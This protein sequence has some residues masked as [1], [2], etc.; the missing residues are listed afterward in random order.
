M[1]QAILPVE[2]IQE[3]DVDL[4]LLEELA[5]DNSFCEWFA[6]ELDLPD[7]TSVNSAWRSVS[8]F[9]L[10]ET[11]ILF[12]Y[13]SNAQKI[14]VLIENKLDASFQNEQFNRYLKRADE[15]M[16]KKECDK[17]FT[18]LIAPEQ[19]CESQS[20][21]ESYLTYELI[22]K[23]LD[24]LGSKRNLFKSKLLQIAIEKLRRGYQPINSIPV[25][26]FWLSYWKNIEE[27]HPT[28]TM[29]KPNIVPH[30]SNWPLLHDDR[31]K[32]IVFCHKLRQGNTDAT[33]KGFPKEV[34]LKIKEILPD[35]AKFEKH[36]RNFSIRVFSGKVDRTKDFYEQIDKVEYGL[37][38]LDKLR[39]WIIEN[40]NWLQQT[41]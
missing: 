1:E 13:N 28:F 12:S 31:L 11:D 24:F 41:V 19:Y 29:E 40:K 38:N 37:Q 20:D 36:N 22:A 18:V 23:R 33:F 27:K 32:N 17:V 26:D 15:Y 21:F 14:F 16:E 34:E 25:Q 35:W 10:G 6:K 30:D 4:I 5:T 8:G 9:G 3:R 7:L 2:A 39:N